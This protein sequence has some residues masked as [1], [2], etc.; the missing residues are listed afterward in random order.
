MAIIKI[1]RKKELATKMAK[2]EVFIDGQLV[3]KLSSGETK[4]F[5][6][7]EGQH[8]VIVKVEKHKQSSQ[9]ISVNTGEISHLVVG[10]SKK[11][12]AIS[13][14]GILSML[15]AT[16]N[17]ICYLAGIIVDIYPIFVILL[18]LLSLCC[19]IYSTYS[20]RILDI[21]IK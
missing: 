16:V 19:M 1:E 17:I 11:Y 9:M 3:G 10:C 2:Y 15:L 20:K 13:L 7:T 18:M 4:E 8:T 21:E 5:T 6:T 14:L 12:A